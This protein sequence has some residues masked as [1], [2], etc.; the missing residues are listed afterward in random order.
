MDDLA[1]HVVVVE[2]TEISK[3][4]VPTVEPKIGEKTNSELISTAGRLV[5][6]ITSLLISN[7]TCH[8]EL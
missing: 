3:V 1:I 8:F 5:F 6:T 7:Y 2:N 4:K